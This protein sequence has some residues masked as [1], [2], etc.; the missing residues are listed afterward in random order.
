MLDLAQTIRNELAERKHSVLVFNEESDGKGT[1]MRLAPK[2]IDRF[3]EVILLATPS[4]Q[5]DHF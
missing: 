2:T 1:A 5:I 3:S 4:L